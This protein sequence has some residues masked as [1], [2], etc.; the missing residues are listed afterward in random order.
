MPISVKKFGFFFVP[1]EVPFPSLF[2]QGEG[3][4]LFFCHVKLFFNDKLSPMDFFPFF[5]NGIFHFGKEVCSISFVK[6][7]SYTPLSNRRAVRLVHPALCCRSPYQ[8]CVLILSPPLL[9]I[10]I[11]RIYFSVTTVVKV[12]FPTF[13][14]PAPLVSNCARSTSTIFTFSGDFSS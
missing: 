9:P 7:V 10:E 5:I 14:D 6:H 1:Q 8:L 4:T 13:S 11:K 3:T 2:A 12:L